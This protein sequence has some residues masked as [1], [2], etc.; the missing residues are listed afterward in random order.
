MWEV[1]DAA[2]FIVEAA[3][4]IEASPRGRRASAGEPRIGR[5]CTRLE[6]DIAAL[7]GQRMDSQWK[8]RLGG[9]LAHSERREGIF[10]HL[11]M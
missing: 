1:R 8:R 7:G 11:G 9:V 5:S 6:K 4:V 3:D 2:S 10:N